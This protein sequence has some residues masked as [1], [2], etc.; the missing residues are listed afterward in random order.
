MLP[1]SA[2]EKHVSIWLVHKLIHQRV[3]PFVDQVNGQRLCLAQRSISVA[4][5]DVGVSDFSKG[6]VDKLLWSVIVSVERHSFQCMPG[7][8][9][10][11]GP[12]DLT[13]SYWQANFGIVW[14]APRHRAS[15][16]VVFSDDFA[17][18]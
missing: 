17:V 7:L 11:H 12:G 15:I 9:L 4:F 10:L 1:F 3:K 5:L 14:H 13:G 18:D 6:M 16:G 2:K 8:K